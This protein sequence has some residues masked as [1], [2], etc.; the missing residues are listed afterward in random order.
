[1][2]HHIIIHYRC[3]HFHIKFYLHNNNADSVLIDTH[4]QF[5]ISQNRL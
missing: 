1:M 3:C 5:S 4:N 2:I